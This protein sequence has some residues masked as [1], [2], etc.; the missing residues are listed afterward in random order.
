[1]GKFQGSFLLDFPA[2]EYMVFIRIA[3]ALD[4]LI[5]SHEWKGLFQFGQAR[6]ILDFLCNVLFF[7]F[8]KRVLIDPPYFLGG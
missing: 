7:I 8:Q 5:G 6:P 2:F 3:I 4:L 1:M